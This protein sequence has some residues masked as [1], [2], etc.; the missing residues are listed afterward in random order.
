MSLLVS[1]YPY[2]HKMDN[3]CIDFKRKTVKYE[4]D[5]KRFDILQKSS[6]KIDRYFLKSDTLKKLA[7]ILAKK[8]RQE[9]SVNEK[10]QSLQREMKQMK[11]G[12]EQLKSLIQESLPQKE[13]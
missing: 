5:H 2:L 4:E 1:E 12:I 8:Q 10:F 9:K 13:I 6:G 7:D 11:L 3:L